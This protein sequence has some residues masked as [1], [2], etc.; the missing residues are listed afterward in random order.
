MLNGT[1]S[2]LVVQCSMY[3]NESNVIQFI[4]HI[5]YIYIY[6]YIY[7]YNTKTCYFNNRYMDLKLYYKPLTMSQFHLDIY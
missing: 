5:L 6:I 4:I 1:H 7:I 2:T 3:Q